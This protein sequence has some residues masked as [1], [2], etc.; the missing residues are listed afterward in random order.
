MLQQPSNF[1]T[2]EYYNPR[3]LRLTKIKINEIFT[4]KIFHNMKKLYKIL[5]LGRVGG[6]FPGASFPGGAIFREAIFLGGLFPGINFFWGG[7]TFLGGIFPGVIFSGGIFPG[8]IFPST[9]KNSH[10]LAGI[11][12]IFPENCPRPNLK[13]LSSRTNFSTDLQLSWQL[14]CTNFRLKLC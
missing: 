9:V 1:R 12:F 8:G 14:S 5:F 7:D 13:V 11:Y 6:N 4:A 2:D 3:K 10:I